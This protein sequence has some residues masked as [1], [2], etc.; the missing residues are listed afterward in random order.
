MKTAST[1][2]IPK[3]LNRLC[4]GIPRAEKRQEGECKAVESTIYGKIVYA[5]R[6]SNGVGTVRFFIVAVLVVEVLDAT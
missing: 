6:F 5:N 2:R 4:D 3:V 1:R